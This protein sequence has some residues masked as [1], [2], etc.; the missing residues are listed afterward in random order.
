MLNQQTLHKLYVMRLNGMADA[1]R[2]QL[3]QPDSAGLSF[4]ER[5][6]MLVDRQWSWKEERALARR[7]RSSR[8]K[9]TASVED[10]DY[11][12][13]RGLDRALVRS[14]ASE[15]EWVKQ[16]QNIFLIGATGVGK[17][18]IACALAHKA[19]RDGYTVYYARSAQLFR[20]LAL[21][22]ADGSFSRLLRRLAQT[23][24][25]L[26]DDFCMAPLTE[27]ERRD[28][29]EICDDRYQTRSTILTS[30]V[31]VP[32]WHAQIGDPT[33]ADSILDRLV[34]NAQRLELK[35]ESM[36]KKRGGREAA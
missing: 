30:Q 10:I 25:L 12:T 5:F 32:G 22:H 28:L 29:L 2:Q 21:A 14:L 16:H 8:L 34:H 24:V 11:Q 17:S 19:C 4:D 6:G 3:E 20:E 23:D 1:F 26:I 9:G 15:S 33:A 18:W 35:G 31:P 27:A 36:R 7:L 13:P